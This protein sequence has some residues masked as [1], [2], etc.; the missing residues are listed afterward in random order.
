MGNPAR[1]R[2]IRNLMSAQHKKLTQNITQKGV[3]KAKLDKL[4][5]LILRNQYFDKGITYN[6]KRFGLLNKVQAL[7]SLQMLNKT[8]VEGLM[9][10]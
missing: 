2:R 8:E 5:S 9:I 6:K 1:R 10:K 3:G 7:L 4:V